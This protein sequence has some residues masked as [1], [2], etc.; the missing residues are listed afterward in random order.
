MMSNAREGLFMKF[1]QELGV[2][3]SLAVFSGGEVVRKQFNRIFKQLLSLL[4]ETGT[5]FELEELGVLEFDDPE[6]WRVYLL[7]TLAGAIYQTQFNPDSFLQGG[8]M[9]YVTLRDFVEVKN[10]FEKD[11][12]LFTNKFMLWQ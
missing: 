4:G 5:S 7:N 12:S 11:E 8:A 2:T 3:Y 9:A 6:V 1:Q 10:Y